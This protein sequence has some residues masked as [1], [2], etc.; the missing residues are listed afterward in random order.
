MQ[1]G[2]MV[3]AFGHKPDYQEHGN[4][5]AFSVDRGQSWMQV[6]PLSSTVTRAYCGVREVSAGE[7]FVVYST[8]DAKTAQDYSKATFNTMGRSVRVTRLSKAI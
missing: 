6:V 2:T 1:D 4:Y 3:M 5:L 8:S 7:L